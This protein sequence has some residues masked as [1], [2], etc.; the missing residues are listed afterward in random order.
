MSVNDTNIKIAYATEI[1]YLVVLI[2]NELLNFKDH[3]N[4]LLSQ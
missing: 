4:L 2:K 1:K 3:P